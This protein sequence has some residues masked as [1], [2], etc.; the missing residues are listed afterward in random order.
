MGTPP[1]SGGSDLLELEFSAR[2]R[3]RRDPIRSDAG[4]C[5]SPVLGDPSWEVSPVDSGSPI[6]RLLQHWFPDWEPPADRREWNPTLCPFHGEEHASASVSFRRN[7]FVCHGC[8]MRGDIPALIMR[9]EGRNYG[10]A[11]SYAERVLGGGYAQVQRKPAGKS[12]R[13]VF[14]RSGT[15]ESAR[16][17]Y[18]R[19]FSAGLR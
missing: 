11:V 16:V 9:K 15:D 13:R 14:G 18:R 12:G 17:G 2:L 6:T 8:G 4:G 19:R 3:S 1:R 10:E 7:A 5:D